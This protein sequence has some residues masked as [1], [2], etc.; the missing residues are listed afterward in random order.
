[1]NWTEEE[2]K[3]LELTPD[4]QEAFDKY[5]SSIVKK[6]NKKKKKNKN[7]KKARKRNRK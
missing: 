7:A 2:L 1:M 4:E 6:R 5:M 3:E